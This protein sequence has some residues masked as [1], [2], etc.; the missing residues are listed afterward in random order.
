L[1]TARPFW[2]YW[3]TC[4]IIKLIRLKIWKKYG[5]PIGQ[6]II[7]NIKFHKCLRMYNNLFNV[8]DYVSC[9][10]AKPPITS[11]PIN[12][13]YSQTIM[14]LLTDLPYYDIMELNRLKIWKIHVHDPTGQNIILNIKQI[15][16]KMSRIIERLRSPSS[17]TLGAFSRIDDRNARYPTFFGGIRNYANISDLFRPN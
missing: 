4:H 9:A 15:I 12:I 8:L 1:S 14:S 5:D 7:L 3:P 16:G 13:E 17:K 10:V 11:H 6:N 2:V